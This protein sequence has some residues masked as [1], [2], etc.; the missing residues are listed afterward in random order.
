MWSKR[1]LDKYKNPKKGYDMCLSLREIRFI[2]NAITHD[3]LIYD[4]RELN[5]HE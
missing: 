1:K 5:C 3:Q 4:I 2:N